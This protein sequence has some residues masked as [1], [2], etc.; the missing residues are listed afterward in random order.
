MRY[1][2]HYTNPGDIVWDGFAGT[3]MTGVAGQLCND[4]TELRQMGFTIEGNNI[5]NQE[6]EKK[7]QSVG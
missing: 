6:G 2:L 1:L 4:E 3:G 5:I 7:Y